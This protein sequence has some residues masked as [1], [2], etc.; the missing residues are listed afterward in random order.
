M[1]VF[2][3]LVSRD[4][5]PSPSAFVKHDGGMSVDWEKYAGGPEGTQRRGNHDATYYGVVGMTA[6]RVRA[7]HPR[8][9][10]EH[11]P[12][13]RN[14]AHSDVVGEETEEEE[15]EIRIKLSRVSDW[16]IRSPRDKKRDLTQAAEAA[17]IGDAPGESGE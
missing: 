10:V 15:E 13:P 2:C 11:R 12:L 8:Q 4:G 7:I 16:L 14:R 17:A 1:R 3:T 5:G 6:V 9:D